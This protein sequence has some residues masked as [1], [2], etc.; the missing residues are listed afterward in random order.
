[1]SDTEG[2]S[3]GTSDGEAPREDEPADEPAN[4]RGAEGESTDRSNVGARFDRLPPTDAD[5]IVPGRA[6]RAAVVGFFEERFGFPP[7]TFEDHT[8]WEKGAGKIWVYAGTA[9]D[10][11]EIEALGMLCLRTRQEHWKPTTDAIQR[12][13]DGA[14]RNVLSLER[15]QAV[16]FVAGEDQSL[17]H[18]GDW[19]YVVV[20]HDIA[21][22]RAV[23]GV[24]LYVH[25]ELR[26]MIP[27]GRRRSPGELGGR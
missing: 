8:F 12:F 20:V 7:A 4:A 2:D 9:P 13:G 6:S 11:L 21:G 5:R 16:R 26:S 25:D 22:D 27:K 1:M 15:E 19:G 24:G 18:D 23:L 10:P 17:E 3:D 14:S